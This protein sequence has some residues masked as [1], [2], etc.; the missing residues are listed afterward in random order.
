MSASAARKIYCCI[1]FV[2]SNNDQKNLQKPVAQWYQTFNVNETSEGLICGM[3]V[4]SNFKLW[5]T[6]IGTRFSVARYDLSVNDD[7]PF[8]ATFLAT[9]KNSKPAQLSTFVSF[10]SIAV[11]YPLTRGNYLCLPTNYPVSQSCFS[12]FRGCS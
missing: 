7:C 3:Y 11:F 2:T 9:D 4:S 5:V 6:Q 10:N 12:I 8:L 1:V